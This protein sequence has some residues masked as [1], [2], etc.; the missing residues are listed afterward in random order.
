MR[1]YRI[2]H[3][4]TGVGPY[5]EAPSWQEEAHCA[6]SGRPT[7]DQETSHVELQ[8][9]HVFGFVSRADLE[10]W[11]TRTERARL[12]AAGYVRAVYEGATA[13]VGRDSGQCTFVRDNAKLV[14]RTK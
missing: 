6:A 10:R 8:P 2:E 9:G 12:R 14:R 13:A 1:I 5:H 11:F 7:I 4:V 3:R